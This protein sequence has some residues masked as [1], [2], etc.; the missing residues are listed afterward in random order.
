MVDDSWQTAKEAW[1]LKSLCSLSPRAVSSQLSL[2]W[3]TA[4]L[5]ISASQSTVILKGKQSLSIEKG[6]HFWASFKYVL[7]PFTYRTSGWWKKII[8]NRML[9]Q[10]NPNYSTFL[11]FFPGDDI[12]GSLCILLL[13]S[14][15]QNQEG[16]RIC[17]GSMASPYI[18]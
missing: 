6:K 4:D 11:L 16:F 18:P 17:L 7:I 2:F 14:T 12:P 1:G 5:T 9:K 13:F 10:G 3:S 15:S 8:S